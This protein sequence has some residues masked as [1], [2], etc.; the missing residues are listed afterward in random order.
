MQCDAVKDG[1]STAID[2]HDHSKMIFRRSYSRLLITK[3][4]IKFRFLSKIHLLRKTC[5]ILKSF[6]ALK[7][8]KKLAVHIFLLHSRKI[9]F[10]IFFISKY[11]TLDFW[12]F[13]KHVFLHF[14]VRHKGGFIR[15]LSFLSFFTTITKKISFVFKFAFC[16]TAILLDT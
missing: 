4:S 10:Q 2:I 12:K 11:L 13:K 7:R 3:E 8:L 15:L 16:R 9:N 5:N 1:E 6:N 14:V